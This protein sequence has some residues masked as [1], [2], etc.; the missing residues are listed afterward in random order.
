M[1]PGLLLSLLLLVFA[2]LG[3]GLA[4]AELSQDGNVRIS[5]EGDFRPHSLP[6][7]RPAPVTINV[8]GRIGTT[9]GSHP[10][11]VRRVEFELN[12]HGRLSTRGLP[13]CAGPRLQS[14]SSETALARCRPA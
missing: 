13:T 1:R 8:R 11:P 2:L 6:R 7:G 4:Q 10:P 3:A 14:T 5:F 9:D 12:R